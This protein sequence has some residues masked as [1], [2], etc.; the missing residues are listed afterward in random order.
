MQAFK[1]TAF[2]YSGVADSMSTTQL[3][4]T[5]ELFVLDGNTLNHLTT[6]LVGFTIC[7][8]CPMQWSKTLSKKMKCLGYDTKLHLVRQKL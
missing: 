2:R 8:L 4:E 7:R 3:L 5:I 1:N 6:L